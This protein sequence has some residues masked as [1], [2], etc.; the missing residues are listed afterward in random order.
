MDKCIL[1]GNEKNETLDCTIQI[2]SNCN[3]QCFYCYTQNDSRMQ[4][5]DLSIDNIKTI[6]K[7]LKLQTFENIILTITGGE[8]T[9]H[10]DLEKIIHMFRN[11]FANK[12]KIRLLTNLL[13]S[14][15]YYN[16]LSI[17]EYLFSY[18]SEYVSDHIY[19]FDKIDNINKQEYEIAIMYHE[20][21][22]KEMKYLYDKYKNKYNIYL[23]SLHNGFEITDDNGINYNVAYDWKLL[24]KYIKHI[25]RWFLCTFNGNCY[26]GFEFPKYS[27]EEFNRCKNLMK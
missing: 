22:W 24:N 1:D 18:H 3:N 15:E 2:T 8:P 17:D 11:E 6:I 16:K 19:W 12:I 5:D 20:H 7:F 10:I 9:L 21:N 25:S 4:G 23:G 14:Y 13:Q 27:I 26:D